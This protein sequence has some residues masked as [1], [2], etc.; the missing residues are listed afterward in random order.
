M[1]ITQILSEVLTYLYYADRKREIRS[2]LWVLAG[3]CICMFC[4]FVCSFTHVLFLPYLLCVCVC[5][6]VYIYTQIYVYIRNEP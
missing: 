5:I 3:V 6:F 2:E 1:Y 4:V